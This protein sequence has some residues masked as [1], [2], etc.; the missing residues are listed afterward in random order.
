MSII[1]AETIVRMRAAI[2]EGLSANR[3]IR[4]VKAIGLSY[5]RTDMLADWRN[6]AGIEK[7]RDLTRFVRK[8]YV[9]AARSVEIERWAMSQEYMYK[10]RCQ[11]TFAGV[12]ADK[13]I[14]IN[15]M[16]DTPRTIEALEREAWERA[17]PQSPPKAGEERQFVVM[18]AIHR[19]EE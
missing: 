10:V 2:T 12:P 3:F 18:S 14:F 16:H 7:Q 5:R 19:A 13:P 1:R 4:E 17:L 8:G 15:I 9:P 11:Q 6:L